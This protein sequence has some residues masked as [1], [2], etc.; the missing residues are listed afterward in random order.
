MDFGMMLTVALATAGGWLI[1]S[2][3]FRLLSGR[4]P[5]RRFAEVT[6]SG[7]GCVLASLARMP[8]LGVSSSLMLVGAAVAIGSASILVA[9]RVR[10]LRQPDARDKLRA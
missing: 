9:R 8:A 3:V 2:G 7:A 1:G 10:A 5:G 6:L 4:I